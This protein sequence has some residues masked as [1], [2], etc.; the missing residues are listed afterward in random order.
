MDTNDHKV[1]YG[2]PIRKSCL[3]KLCLEDDLE[4]LREKQVENCK[5][6][7]FINESR[8]SISSPVQEKAKSLLEQASS[9]EIKPNFDANIVDKRLLLSSLSSLK[10]E[11]SISICWKPFSFISSLNAEVFNRVRKKYGITVE[12][13]NAPAAITCFQDMRIPDALYRYLHV[14]Q[15]IEKPSLI[16]MQGIPSALSG[17][18]II[19]IASTG[20]GKTLAFCIPLIIFS[21]EQEMKLAFEPGE[22]PVSLILAPSRELARQIFEQCNEIASYLRFQEG[23]KQLKVANLIGGLPMADQIASVKR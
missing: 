1:V 18:D 9:L 4:D 11:N 22:G 6:N 7:M 16:Q 20:T 2:K 8:D 13:S 14:V 21:L 5:E 10:R 23:F 12:A 19:G 3:P 17:R 15:K